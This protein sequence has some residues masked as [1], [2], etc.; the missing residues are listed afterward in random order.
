MRN[1]LRTLASILV[2]AIAACGAPAPSG[3]TAAPALVV[4]ARLGVGD[5][6]K[7]RVYGE[8]ELSGE[9]TVGEDGTILFP[10]LGRVKAGGMTPEELA[11][12]LARELET[13]GYLKRPQ[14]NVI[15]EE[16][17]SK[18]VS[19]FGSVSKP[20]NFPLVSGLTVVQA[21]SLA[22]GLT[23]IAN[24]NEVVITRRSGDTMRRITVSI[25]KI[26]R[27]QASDVPLEAGDIVYVPERVF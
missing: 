25:T 5:S 24:A 22:G 4:D 21:I 14:V 20:G 19:V 11:E 9:H 3:T 2:V 1:P 12:H 26:T 13:R 7:V 8:D 15:V 23:S 18:R 17:V 16:Y 10:F 6:F 27:G